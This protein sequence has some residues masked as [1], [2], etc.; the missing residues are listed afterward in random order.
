MHFQSF[1]NSTVDKTEW[2]ASGTSIL[3]SGNKA[4]SFNW[5]PELTGCYGEENFVNVNNCP[6]RCN[7]VQFI[8]FL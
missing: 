4:P 8:I 7:Y 6:T 3:T 2:C 5:F 1:L